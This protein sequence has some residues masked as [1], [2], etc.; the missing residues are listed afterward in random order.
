MS[1]LS[2]L[3]TVN[4]RCDHL[5]FTFYPFPSHSVMERHGEVMID[6]YMNC[7]HCESGICK[8]GPPD[9]YRPICMCEVGDILESDS[10]SC[11]GK[12]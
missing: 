10:I 1:V 5:T 9:T 4:L 6:I 8:Q 11:T 3:D 12:L 7:S 2:E